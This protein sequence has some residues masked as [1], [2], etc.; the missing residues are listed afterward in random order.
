MTL[1]PVTTARRREILVF[2]FTPVRC[3]V[4]QDLLVDIAT[5]ESSF[6]WLRE[7]VDLPMTIDMHHG[8]I[9]LSPG[10]GRGVK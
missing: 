9:R 5:R 10:E 2:S 7:F 1:F 3:R 6:N 8:V 4:N